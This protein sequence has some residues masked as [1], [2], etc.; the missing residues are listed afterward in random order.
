MTFV[1]RFQQRE[2][3]SY[4]FGTDKL[5]KHAQVRWQ[6]ERVGINEQHWMIDVQ[7]RLRF[8][9]EHPTVDNDRSPIFDIF[10]L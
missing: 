8:Q 7:E 3:L 2:Y 1:G 9:W 6:V 4:T 5:L 10:I